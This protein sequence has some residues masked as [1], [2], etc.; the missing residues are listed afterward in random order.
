[1]RRG[2]LA[3]VAAAFILASMAES[4]SA[5]QINKIRVAF[6]SSLDDAFVNKIRSLVDKYDTEDIIDFVLMDNYDGSRFDAI[7]YLIR[8]KDEVTLI[9]DLES[10]PKIGDHLSKNI[11]AIGRR[12]FIV[13]YGLLDNKNSKKFGFGFYFLEEYEGLEYECFSKSV[14]LAIR[15]LQEEI[16]STDPI[17]GMHGDLR[18]E[19]ADCI[20]E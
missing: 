16:S 20:R 6:T 15:G 14:F 3:L 10:F 7:I 19:E 2:L 13:N 17:I 11:E 12:Y 1:M 5:H 8:R 18:I 4:T 9:K